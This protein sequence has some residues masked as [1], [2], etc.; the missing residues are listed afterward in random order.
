MKK[1]MFFSVLLVLV[2]LLAG[3]GGNQQELDI[4]N[5]DLG[6]AKMDLTKAQRELATAQAN[7]A[8]AEKQLAALVSSKDEAAAL[9]GKVAKLE[10]EKEDLNDKL[11]AAKEKGRALQTEFDS[12][13]AKYRAAQR[14]V[15]GFG[16]AIADA[17]L[18]AYNQGWDDASQ[19]AD[20]YY[21]QNVQYQP[22]SVCPHC[23]CPNYQH[24]TYCPYYRSSYYTPPRPQSPLHDFFYRPFGKNPRQGPYY[25][26]PR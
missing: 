24:Y 8:A 10:G 6:V 23:S 20:E 13:E 21:R 26:P 18:S 2:L 22:S 11:S 25:R 5:R 12:L 1:G 17:R 4:A 15:L 16:T 7:Y 3:C 9:K 19:A 14:E